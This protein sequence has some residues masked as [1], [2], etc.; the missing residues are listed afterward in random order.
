MTTQ[1]D[2]D[3]LIRAFLAEGRT[4][5]PDR[6]Y[7]AIRSDIERTRQRV[8]IGPWRPTFMNTYVKLAIAAAA[9]VVVAVIGF[10]LLPA[11]NR[12][13]GSPSPTPAASPTPATTPTPTVAPTPRPTAVAVFPPAGPI[14]PGTY[15]AVLEGIRVSFTVSATGW[16]VS[17][18]NFVGTASYGQPAD[19]SFNMWPNSPDNVYSDPCGHTPLDPAP[20]YTAADLIAAAAA[21]P[22]TDLV[23]APSSVTVAGR[24]AQHVA[25]TIRDDIA[26]DPQDFWLWYDDSGR[27]Q[28][29]RWAGFVGDTHQVWTIDVDGKVIWI[30]SET[31]E[32]ATPEAEQTVQ[33]FIDSIQ[34]E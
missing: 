5:L 30:D 24:P 1:R 23:S 7:D 13:T 14:S 16:V 8:V 20:G 10:N 17:E 22:G 28:D 32:N 3:R 9:V 26:C 12:Q 31:F 11:D 27:G 25:F 18:G 4:D 15:T 19:V 6:A 2:P 21:I 34:I 33:A 29:W